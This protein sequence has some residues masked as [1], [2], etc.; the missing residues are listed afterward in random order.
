MPDTSMM[1]WVTGPFGGVAVLLLGV[2]YFKTRFDIALEKE[3]AAYQVQIELLRAEI[4][5]V[6]DKYDHCQ[7]THNKTQEY[8]LTMTRENATLLERVRH[9]EKT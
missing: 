3:R 1:Q 4:K 6:S 2:W 8:I 7:D 5:V 9:L